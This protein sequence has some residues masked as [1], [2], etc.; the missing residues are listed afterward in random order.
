MGNTIIVAPTAMASRS[1]W[2]LF[3]DNLQE[4]L[5]YVEIMRALRASLKGGQ[6]NDARKYSSYEVLIK[7]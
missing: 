3:I 7:I 2:E 6:T 4:G 1:Y 5:I